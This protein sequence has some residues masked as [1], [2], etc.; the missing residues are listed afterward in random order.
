LDAFADEWAFL[1]NILAG[2]NSRYYP[3]NNFYPAQAREIG[4]TDSAA[5]DYRLADHSSYKGAA[6]DGRDAGADID[7]VLR[8]TE[9]VVEGGNAA[10]SYSRR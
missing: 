6:T 10:R 2:A 8:A 4:F 9:G 3:A 5:G 1:G 7:Q